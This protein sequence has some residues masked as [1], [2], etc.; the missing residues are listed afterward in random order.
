MALKDLKRTIEGHFG[1][2]DSA[3]LAVFVTS[4]SFRRGLPRDADLV[5]DAR[6]LRNP[7][8]DPVLRSLTG[9]DGP[10]GAYIEGDPDFAVFFKRL[11]D[12]LGLLLPRF[13]QEGKSYLTIAIGCT[14]GRH[15]SVFIAE[16]LGIWLG[17]RAARV[18]VRHRELRDVAP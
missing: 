15:R 6:F 8:Y 13:Q 3:G 1:L 10:V 14:G 2:E 18:D 5:F 11:T 16:K 4:F 17:E 7:H 9:N 12:L